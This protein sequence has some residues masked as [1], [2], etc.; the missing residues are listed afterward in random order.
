MPARVA[1]EAER[2]ARGYPRTAAP[3]PQPRHLDCS[4]RRPLSAQNR[5]MHKSTRPCENSD[6]A[7]GDAMLERR[8]RLRRSI[9]VYST[10]SMNYSCYRPE[11]RRVSHGLQYFRLAASGTQHPFH[12]PFF[13]V[14]DL[15]SLQIE[16]VHR[17]PSRTFP[18]P[19]PRRRANKTSRN[20]AG[21]APISEP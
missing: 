6:A 12:M 20:R 19:C 9:I 3:A 13:W 1:L 8:Q 11:W 15:L 18:Q 16:A 21:R 17:L 2:S 14:V 7:S 10:L 5:T 4:R